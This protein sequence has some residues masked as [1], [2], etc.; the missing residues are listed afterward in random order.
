MLLTTMSA[1]E[2][3]QYGF[4]RNGRRTWQKRPLTSMQDQSYQYDA[5]N[6]VNSA[7]RGS[8]NLNGAAISGIPSL[9]ESWNY[10]PTGNWRGYHTAANGAV[11]LEQQRVHD[12]GNRMTQINNAYYPVIL[13]QA[14]RIRESAPDAD[15]NWGG[16]LA[17][18]WDAWS[19]VKVVNSGGFNVGAYTYDG[20]NRRI[21]REVAGAT[22]RSYYNDQWRPV[23]ECKNSQTTAALSYLWGARHRDDLVRRDRAV[24]GTTLNEMRYVLMDYFNPSAITDASGTVKERYEFSAFGVRTILNP[25]YSVRSSSECA[26]EFG[27]QGQFLD[28]ESGLMNYGYRYYSPFLGRW[29]CKDPIAERGGLNLYAVAANNVANYVDRLGLDGQAPSNYEMSGCAAI[30]PFIL[31]VNYAFGHVPSLSGGRRTG[32]E[33]DSMDITNSGVFTNALAWF[34]YEWMDSIEN[35][36]IKRAQTETY[37]NCCVNDSSRFVYEDS[38]QYR[39]P[40]EEVGTRLSLQTFTVKWKI[41]CDMIFELREKTLELCIG[42]YICNG[43]FELSDVFDF[44]ANEGDGPIAKIPECILGPMGVP[45]KVTATWY[46]DFIGQV[47]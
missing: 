23:E 16:R 13:D 40:I 20:L 31:M 42:H 30:G 5:L 33:H 25:D 7:A 17:L 37:L 3:T 27:F 45:F 24:G 35:E 46:K 18:T 11:T 43:T 29:M 10:D 34:E 12:R 36:M 22:W 38:Q 9:E 39:V 47:P 6:Q 32:S 28:A 41:T 4:D 44:N 2:Q 8:L 26:M 14:G 1:L 15:G 19:R 21:M